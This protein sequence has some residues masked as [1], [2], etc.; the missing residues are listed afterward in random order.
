MA[1]DYFTFD[2]CFDE[3]GNFHFEDLEDAIMSG[4]YVPDRFPD[5]AIMNGIYIPE[6]W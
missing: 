3:E 6:Y 4:V 1:E 2:D 5:D